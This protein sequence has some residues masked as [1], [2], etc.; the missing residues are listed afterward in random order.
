MPYCLSSSYSFD[1]LILSCG[2]V[3][4]PSQDLAAHLPGSDLLVAQ[5]GGGGLWGWVRLGTCP[6]PWGGPELG[7]HSEGQD[8]GGGEGGELVAG[9]M[10]VRWAGYPFTRRAAR[11]D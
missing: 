7:S 5:L 2:I 10:V 3:W 8:R 9:V 4:P 11:E 1:N 6:G